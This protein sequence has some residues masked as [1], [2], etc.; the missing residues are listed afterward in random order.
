MY[1]FN[2]NNNNY[3]FH[4]IY[5]FKVMINRSVFFAR[6]WLILCTLIMVLPL[7]VV[8]S[9][10]GEF[11]QEIWQFLLESELTKLVKNTLI[12]LLT[13]SFGV[14]V[15]GVSSAWLTA[16]YTF[17]GR[18]LFFWAMMLPLTV[19]AY[20][21]AF[22]QLAFVQLGM[23]DYTG[24]VSSYLRSHA[25]WAQGLPDI[26]NIW[27][28][29]WVLILTFYPY[30]Y[31]LARNAFTSMGQQA[32]D[33][34]ASLGLTP[35]QSLFKIALP[36]ARPWVM[37]GLLLAMM[38]ILADF[39]AVS[40]FGVETFTTA[41]YQ[42]WFGFF[43]IDT[44]K[45][46]ASL[47]VLLVFVL[48]VLEQLSRGRRHFATKKSAEIIPKKLFGLKAG[49][50]TG[51]CGLMLVMG[52]LLPIWQ[53]LIWALKD[54]RMDQAM[55][56][57]APM[58]NS[59]LIGLIGA[60]L[61][62]GVALLLVVAKRGD[63]SRFASLLMRL[64][65]LG[66]AIPGSVLAIGIFIPVAYVDNFLLSWLSVAD[67][68]TAIIK[69]T[70][71]VML[72]AYVIRFLALA[73]S[74]VES[75]FERIRPS[76]VESA[77]ILNVRGVQLVRRL[78]VP[79]LKSSLGVAMLMVFVDLMK[80]MPIT[81]MTRPTDWDTLAVRIYAFTMEGQFDQA[82]LPA[83]VIVLSGLIPVILFSK[84]GNPS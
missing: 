38:E 61:V 74:S 63:S 58:A 71:V 33:M 25:G 72:L 78:Y 12:L 81:L 11:D 82:A 68:R 69:G 3:H 7:L 84:E 43:S 66:Y 20:V 23:F 41:I 46:L 18:R 79:L 26:R 29:S 32:L 62:M 83:L 65:T 14:L 55:A 77:L 10:F 40:V 36:M 5:G 21:L 19:P 16:M 28:L 57:L 37:S 70:L 48:I 49:L 35:T 56:L 39:G 64:A 51:F 76:L 9:S 75:G 6:L 73:V 31:L 52:F 34:G 47:L 15:V 2:I 50:A 45:Q 17:P 59:L 27:G 54:W 8:V 4:F 80:E 24:A 22:V 13:T 67:D 44:A 53:L 60:V 1:V 42:A 30:V